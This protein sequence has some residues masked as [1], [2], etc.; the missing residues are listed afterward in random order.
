MLEFMVI[1][2]LVLL[3][4]APADACMHFKEQLK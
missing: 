4:R 3:P 2:V 1:V